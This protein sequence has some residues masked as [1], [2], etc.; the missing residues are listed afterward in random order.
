MFA[1]L[2]LLVVTPTAP[3]APIATFTVTAPRSPR[4]LQSYFPPYDTP[5]AAGATDH[6]DMVGITLDIDA[7]GRIVGC[8]ILKSSG[9]ADLDMTTCRILR[10]VQ[11][12]PARD[13]RSGQ[14]VPGQ[15]VDFI[16]RKRP[17]AAR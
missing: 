8:W 15:M 16:W 14:A 13:T 7:G 9:S 11:M 5:V 4:P 1:A 12:I 10:R 17:Q 2:L 6:M 3:T